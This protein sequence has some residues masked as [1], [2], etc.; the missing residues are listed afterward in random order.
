MQDGIRQQ[1]KHP[2]SKNTSIK[3]NNWHS[4]VKLTLI[5]LGK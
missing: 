1:M 2:K 3:G 5:W 4:L